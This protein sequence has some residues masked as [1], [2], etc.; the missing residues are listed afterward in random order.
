MG[1][2]AFEHDIA[3]KALVPSCPRAASLNAV[4]QRNR[5]RHAA[6][7]LPSPGQQNL[8]VI[9]RG[10]PAIVCK[11]CSHSPALPVDV[12]AKS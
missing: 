6:L 4:V 10:K 12:N 3:R 7:A 2:S 8:T 5:Q 1:I 9:Q 11:K